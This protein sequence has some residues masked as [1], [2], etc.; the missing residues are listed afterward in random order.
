MKKLDHRSWLKFPATILNKFNNNKKYIL[1]KFLPSSLMLLFS[2][3]LHNFLRGVKDSILVPH[4]GPELISFIKFYGVFPGT[5]IFFLCFTKLANMLNRDRLYYT[6]TLFFG[7]FFMLYV[8]VLSPFQQFI[9]PDL[10]SLILSYPKFKYHLM[11]MQHWT[12]SLVYVMCELCGTVMLAFY[13]GNL[14]MSYIPLKK[15]RKL[16]HYLELLVK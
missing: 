15:L 2:A 13:F 5:I 4:L 14:L 10:S 12:T 1:Y 7:L 8:F 16:M 9:E 11:M 3:Y 6:I